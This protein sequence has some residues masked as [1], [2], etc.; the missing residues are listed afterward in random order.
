MLKKFSLSGIILIILLLCLSSNSFSQSTENFDN[1]MIEGLKK[2]PLPFFFGL[3][4]ANAVPQNEFMDEMPKVGMGFSINGG[5]YADPIP[6]A[7]GAEFS[8]LFNG[9]TDSYYEWYWTDPMNHRW[10]EKDTAS[11]QNLMMPFNVFVR[12]QPNIANIFMPYVEGIVGLNIWNTS[13]SYKTSYN[14]NNKDYDKTDN[15]TSVAFNYGF[16]VGFLVKLVDFVQ[17]PATN[18]A[19]CFDAR[20]RYLKGSEIEYSEWKI[21]NDEVKEY[22]HKSTTD[23]ILTQIGFTVR[24]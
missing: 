16:G 12:L 2:K 21:E 15:K 20:M 18:V 17:L 13:Y 19:L 5:W 24:F 9:S 11:T 10:Y 14:Y 6:V 22:T 7:V 3:S 1:Q 4:Y 8:F 23:I